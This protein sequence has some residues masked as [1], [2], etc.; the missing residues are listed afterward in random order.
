MWYTVYHADLCGIQHTAY[1]V[2]SV[3]F[4][5]NPKD[6]LDCDGPGS[7]GGS[8]ALP[9]ALPMGSES[10]GKSAGG[11]LAPPIDSEN[12]G[13]ES[14]SSVMTV[15]CG[16]RSADRLRTVK[17]QGRLR[18]LRLRVPT[19]SSALIVGFVGISAKLLI[20]DFQHLR[21]FCITW[22]MFIWFSALLPNDRALLRFTLGILKPL[23][24]LVP[25]SG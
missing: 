19:M 24:I 25:K 8:L 10:S 18:Q 5:W 14:I 9:M 21:D 17:R 12:T 4:R 13:T 11:S 2:D 22:S 7:A 6:E 1:L 23:C 20:D 3:S 15:G 16:S